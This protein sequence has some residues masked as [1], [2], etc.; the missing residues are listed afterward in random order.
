MKR[1]EAA[2]LVYSRHD[3]LG[4]SVPRVNHAGCFRFAEVPFILVQF[5]GTLNVIV[6]RLDL[7]F[8]YNPANNAFCICYR[9]RLQLLHTFTTNYL[10]K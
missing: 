9:R 2:C 6:D 4:V 10:A 8:W 7:L 3:H 5:L 1:A